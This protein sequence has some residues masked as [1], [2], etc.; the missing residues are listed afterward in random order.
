[1]T[2]TRVMAVTTMTTTRAT[3]T[4]TSRAEAVVK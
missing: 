1:M 3:T 2:T 4:K